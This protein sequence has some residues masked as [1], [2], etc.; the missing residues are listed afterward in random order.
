[1]LGLKYS[2][3]TE[4]NF[5]SVPSLYVRIFVAVTGLWVI[6]YWTVFIQPFFNF[7]CPSTSI[8]KIWTQKYMLD[9]FLYIKCLEAWLCIES[10]KVGHPWMYN[11]DS[12]RMC[13]FY[14]F[15]LSLFIYL[16]FYFSFS[17]SFHFYVASWVGNID[18]FKWLVER[19]CRL[20]R[21]E[22]LNNFK[23]NGWVRN[24]CCMKIPAEL[25]K[26]LLVVKASRKIACGS[27]VRWNACS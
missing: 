19:D 12:R 24:N 25:P 13:G 2:R 7:F 23:T 26:H 15:F 4:V 27:S 8:N 9:F 22:F 21:S 11:R 17:L 5:F 16:F 1:M 10:I 20:L 14:F 6:S 18:I 3:M